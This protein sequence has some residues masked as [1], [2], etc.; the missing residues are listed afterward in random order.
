MTFNPDNLI[1]F[2]LTGAIILL[3]MS[4]TLHAAISEDKKKHKK[5]R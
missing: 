2:Y 4:I 3:A 1:F 5:H